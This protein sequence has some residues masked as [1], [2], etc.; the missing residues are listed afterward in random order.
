MRR[1][2]A[3]VLP[4]VGLRVDPA[5]LVPELLDLDVRRLAVAIRAV[6]GIE[7]FVWLVDVARVP[8]DEAVALLLGRGWR[9]CGP[10]SAAPHPADTT[11][12]PVRGRSR[13]PRRTVAAKESCSPWRRLADAGILG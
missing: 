12:R 10:R 7:A 5:R 6:T 9:C 4:E 8:R 1:G 13:P 11:R 3:D 2:V